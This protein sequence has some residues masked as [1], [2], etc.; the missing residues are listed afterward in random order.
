MH[1]LLYEWH[2]ITKCLRL[3]AIFRNEKNRGWIDDELINK[4]INI[5]PKSTTTGLKFRCSL[6]TNKWKKSY[7]IP[8]LD[9]SLGYDTSSNTM[10]VTSSCTLVIFLLPLP[11]LSLA[12][13][14]NLSF[15]LTSIFQ[16]SNLF[17]A[18]SFG[19]HLSPSLSSSNLQ[20]SA[21]KWL[22][23]KYQDPSQ[24]SN[25]QWLHLC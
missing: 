8:L 2:Y 13:C 11:A 16:S 10:E 19:M 12:F 23:F 24:K 20:L 6:V 4:D 5:S 18:L 7:L 22:S 17:L 1:H 14:S 21:C 25:H 9:G 15:L 3:Q